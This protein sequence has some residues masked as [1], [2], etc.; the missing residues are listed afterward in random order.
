VGWFDPKTD[1]VVPV[2][3][4]AQIKGISK[5]KT[6][7]S[8]KDV[9]QGRGPVGVAIRGGKVVCNDIENDPIMGTK[10][11]ALPGIPIFNST[12]LKKIRQSD[13]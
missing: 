1:K 12:T 8:N 6:I 9:P 3:I 7:S 5:I 10:E 13:W 4:S 2:M 11:E